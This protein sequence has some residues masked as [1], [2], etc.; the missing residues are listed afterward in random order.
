MNNEKQSI[1]SLARNFIH[2]NT[3]NIRDNSEKRQAKFVN[4]RVGYTAG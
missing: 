2:R 4:K 3:L 1:N